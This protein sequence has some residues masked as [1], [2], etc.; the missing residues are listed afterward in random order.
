MGSALRGR[1]P[2][3]PAPARPAEL[4]R[5]GFRVASGQANPFAVEVLPQDAAFSLHHPDAGDDV[6]RDHNRSGEDGLERLTLGV[7]SVIVVVEECAQSEVDFLRYRAAGPRRRP[8]CTPGPTPPAPRPNRESADGPRLGR[9]GSS[10][11]RHEAHSWALRPRCRFPSAR[12]QR[13]L[14][15][16]GP[17]AGRAPAPLASMA[18]FPGRKGGCQPGRP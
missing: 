2:S 3:R 6:V 16:Q 18:R 11:G 8:P 5:R 10:P 9:A 4:P 7:H 13:P 15:R 14:L 1:T 17:C 12:W